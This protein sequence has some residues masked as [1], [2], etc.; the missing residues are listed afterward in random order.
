MRSV[1]RFPAIVLAMVGGMTGTSHAADIKAP[2]NVI[3]DTDIWSDIDDMLALAMLHTLQDRRELNLVAVTISS[4]DKWCAP[5]VD[6]V[7]TF[8][9]HEQIPIGIVRG[10]VTN[11]M[12]AKKFPKGKWPLT[13]YTQ[14][15]SERKKPDGSP[16]YPH[17]LTDGSKVPEAVS[18]LRK[19]LAAQ[20]D[21]SVVIIQ[22]G[23]STNLA[24]LLESGADT[25]SSLSGRDLV[26]KKVRLLSAMAGNFHDAAAE[27]QSFP[28]GSPEFNVVGDVPAAQKVFSEWP[29]PVVVS[30]FEIGLSMRYPA[31]SIEQD[32]SYVANHPIADTYVSYCEEQKTRKCPH[33]HPTYDLTSVLYA[34]RPDRNY[35]SL[36]KPGKVTVLEDGGTRFEESA[37]GLQRHLILD[38]HQKAR[39]LEAMAMLSSQPP[40]HTR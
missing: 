37:G 36:S 22:V 3:F 15:I 30:G 19:T 8:Y 11:E 9:G 31:A 14:Y 23:F 25:N 32:Y 6:L 39:T 18:L 2:I 35:F 20:P 17:R 7:N 5:Y 21:G 10:G 27:G 24:R 29:T 26:K 16:L 4:D 38:E 33:E 40:V 1:K 34:A 13:L 12:L 28:K